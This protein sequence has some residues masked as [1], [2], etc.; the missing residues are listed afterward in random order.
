MQNNFYANKLTLDLIKKFIINLK[1]HY[2]MAK[3]TRAAATAKSKLSGT[4]LVSVGKKAN[5]KAIHSLLDE[6]FKLNGCLTCGLGGIDLTLRPG[7]VI[8]P[9]FNNEGL[10]MLGR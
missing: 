3:A 10:V 6:I 2:T 5:A 7:E 4:V 8:L 1:T 9:Q